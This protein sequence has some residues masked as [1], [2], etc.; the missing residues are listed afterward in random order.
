MKK[1]TLLVS[2]VF[3]CAFLLPNDSNAQNFQQGDVIIGAGVGLGST[4]SVS[5]G[6]PIIAQAEFGITD[7][8]GVGPYVGF[9]DFTGFTIFYIGGRGIYHWGTHIDALPEELDLYGGI[10]LFYRNIDVDGLGRS[11]SNGIRGGAFAGARYYFNGNNFGVFAELGSSISYSE[12]GV[13]LK[14]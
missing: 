5:G 3:L 2:L 13:V 9:N 1:L 7:R 12:I 6:L 4:F 11:F 10:A 14:L 8:I